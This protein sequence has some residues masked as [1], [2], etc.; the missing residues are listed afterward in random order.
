MTLH[1]I[2]PPGQ[3]SSQFSLESGQSRVVKGGKTQDRL[4]Q[5]PRHDF[6]GSAVGC[7]D[8]GSGL[9][10]SESTHGPVYDERAFAE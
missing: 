4:G 1:L 7:V 3:D 10:E 9:L 6:P 2:Y 5:P 8:F